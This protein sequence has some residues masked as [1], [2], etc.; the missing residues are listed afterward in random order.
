MNNNLTFSV[1]KLCFNLLNLLLDRLVIHLARFTW[2]TNCCGQRSIHTSRRWK[3]E[4]L[5]RQ[6]Y[7]REAHIDPRHDP[8]E[9]FGHGV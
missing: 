3:K 1:N 5:V 9:E 6:F 7:F 4:K 8:K 2:R